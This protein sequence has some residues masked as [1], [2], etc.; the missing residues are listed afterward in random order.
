MRAALPVFVLL[1]GCAALAQHPTEDACQRHDADACDELA[2]EA[3]DVMHPND[4]RVALERKYCDLG[5][6]RACYDA[7]AALASARGETAETADDLVSFTQR[8][9]ARHAIAGCN[10]LAHYAKDAIADCD[11]GHDVRN[12][13]AAAGV[14]Y[15]RGVDVPPVHGRSVE[16]DAAKAQAA[17]AKSCAAG[18]PSSCNR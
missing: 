1:A 7:A 18:A 8:A 10:T 9:C 2:A 6:A 17:F 3:I 12:S 13:C 15:V 4:D 14:V 16:P 5:G 11:A